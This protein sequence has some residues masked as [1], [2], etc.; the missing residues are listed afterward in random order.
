MT[1]AAPPQ[2]DGEDPKLDPVAQAILDAL[3]AAPS[4][5][6]IDPQQVARDLAAARAKPSDPRWGGRV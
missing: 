2:Q 5:A 3:A 6:K 4:H 1:T